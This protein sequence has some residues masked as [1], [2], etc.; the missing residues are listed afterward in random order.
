MILRLVAALDY[1]LVNR[2]LILYSIIISLVTKC[3]IQ[4]SEDWVMVQWPVLGMVHICL[5][6]YVLI[7]L[8]QR[9]L[10]HLCQ[11]WQSFSGFQQPANKR[12]ALDDGSVSLGTQRTEKSLSLYIYNTYVYIYI[13]VNAYI[14]IHTDTLW[15]TY[16]Y[17]NIYIYVRVYVNYI[18]I[19]KNGIVLRYMLLWFLKARRRR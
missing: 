10:T 5:Q 11:A 7:P 16:I 17:N 9:H 8:C 14:Y 12:R 19:Y 6:R 18:N 15:Y 13:Y 3:N 4:I 2:S 1:M